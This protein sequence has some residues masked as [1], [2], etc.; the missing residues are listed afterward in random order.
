MRKSLKQIRLA[1]SL[2][3]LLSFVA[4]ILVGALLLALPISNTNGQWLNMVDSLFTSTSAVCVTGLIVVDTAVQFTLFGELVILMLIQI[5]G[6]GII[7]VTSFVF[8]LLRKKINMANRM[9]IQES[10]NKE[11]MQGVVKFIKKT[12]LVSLAIEFVGMILLLYSTISYTGNFWTGL[13]S[14]I[15]MSIS[16]FCNA[17]FDVF[18]SE[19][20]QF[21]SLYSFASS[22]TMLLPLMMLIIIGGL[23]FVVL[24]DIFEKSHNKQHTRIVLIMTSVLLFGGAVLFMIFEWNNPDTLGPMSTGDKILNGFFQS[25]TTR[26]A[27]M[28]SLDQ[29]V[30]TSNSKFLTMF[31]MFIG[32]AP[33]STAGGIKVTTFFILL[34]F[35][36][37]LPNEAGDIRLKDRRV[38]RKILMKAFRIVIYAVVTLIISILLVNAFDGESIPLECI[39]FEC[40]SALS[41]VGLSMGITPILSLPSKFV[42]ILLMFVGRVGFATIIMA[43]TNKMANSKVQDIEFSNT[44]IVIG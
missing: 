4:I 38:S 33:N 18:G 17:G 34:L 11:T 32:G 39:L 28:A 37:R 43:I 36:F 44:D 5:G 23:G 27:G 3:I 16:S 30:L 2:Q 22:V 21:A 24:F 15:F 25:V 7:A 14:A 42:I 31:L 9:T 20:N 19:M 10:L 13:Y 6:L 26:T 1:P 41:T 29:S 8:I 35:M 12:I 40:V